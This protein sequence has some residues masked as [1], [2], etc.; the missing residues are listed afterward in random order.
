[1]RT[2]F[3]FLLA[4]LLV[5]GPALAAEAVRTGAAAFGDWRTDSPG[6]RRL[7]TPADL[8]P[9]FAT[10]SAAN[11]SRGA[12]RTPAVLPN[13]PLGFVVDLFAEGLAEPRVI[14]TAPN[15]DI[16][17]AES[18]AG[19]IRIFRPDAAGATPEGAVFAEGLVRPFGIAFYPSADPHW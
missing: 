18:G 5:G 4:A 2:G 11:P 10:P 19:R 3:A 17:V 7:I 16:F 12:P 13:A 14:R 1:M 9:P 8:P 15:G 6:V